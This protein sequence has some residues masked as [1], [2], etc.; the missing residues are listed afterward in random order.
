MND[1]DPIAEPIYD[2]WRP[3]YGDAGWY[4]SPPRTS[5]PGNEWLAE[6]VEGTFVALGG[7]ARPW[8]IGFRGETEGARDYARVLAPGE[9]RAELAADAV[10]A[11]RGW[12]CPVAHFDADLDLFAYVRTKTSRWVPE[13]VWLRLY[14]HLGLRPWRGEAPG[15]GYL[16]FAHGLMLPEG[17]YGD[18]NSELHQLNQPLV[19]DT[20]RRWET[21]AGPIDGW[22]G[23]RGV[24]R[25]GYRE[26]AS[27][28]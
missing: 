11:L 20:L 1:R 24:W 12:T 9:S 22:E 4:V 3:T 28:G 7:L 14:S 25:Y 17:L 18:D 15:G 10:R 21:V 5:S 13:R 19:E 2:T 8:R 26:S 27:G 6:L 16:S 23:S